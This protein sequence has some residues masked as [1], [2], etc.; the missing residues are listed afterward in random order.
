M[1]R[2]RASLR[3]H[4]NNPCKLNIQYTYI[5]V[6]RSIRVRQK[7]SWRATLVLMMNARG[8]KWCC[9]SVLVKSFELL[10]LRQWLFKCKRTMLLSSKSTVWISADIDSVPVSKF[11]V[12]VWIKT[13]YSSSV[14]I[15][16]SSLRE[17]R[18]E[19]KSKLIHFYPPINTP[20]LTQSHRDK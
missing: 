12:C 20:R 4:N 6:P 18:Q 15:I 2:E 19:Q 16:C 1:W 7:P 11:K 13:C 9:A 17:Q 5:P 10:P 8:D 14:G 3:E